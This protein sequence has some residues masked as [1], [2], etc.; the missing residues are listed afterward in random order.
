MRKIS[1]I[2]AAVATVLILA[3]PSTAATIRL[4]LVLSGLSSPL[5]VTNAHDGSNRL[6]IVEQ[7]GRI[8]VLQP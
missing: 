8:K 3:Y 4:V 5:F 2:I 7:G 6:F 1:V